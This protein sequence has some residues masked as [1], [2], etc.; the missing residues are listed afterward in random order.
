[1]LVFDFWG[2]ITGLVVHHQLDDAHFSHYFAD[3]LHHNYE[4]GSPAVELVIELECDGSRGFVQ[5]LRDRAVEKRVWVTSDSQRRLYERFNDLPSPLATPLPPFVLEPLRSRFRLLHASAVAASGGG[6]C[7]VITGPSRGGKS[8][9][10]L[11]LLTAGWRFM[12]DDVVPIDS[13]RH[14]HRYTRPMN[15]RER[16]LQAFPEIAQA[17]RLTSVVADTLTGTTFMAR[18]TDLGFS[19]GPESAPIA[20]SLRLSLASRFEVVQTGE[21]E[22]SVR[23]NPQHHREEF[24]RH[25]VRSWMNGR[26]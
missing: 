11:S 13:S 5:S 10:L 3:Y 12:S 8:T 25:V 24:D 4:D 26:A 14:A 17:V 21:N 23:W 2:C 7:H 6:R 22:L 9:A 15:I 1:M 18:P 16:T 20:G 19:L